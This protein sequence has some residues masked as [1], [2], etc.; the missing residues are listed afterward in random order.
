MCQ[1]LFSK[2]FTNINS[3][4]P[5]ERL[6]ERLYG[7]SALFLVCRRANGCSER[8]REAVEPGLKTW[9]PLSPPCSHLP[10]A[11][12]AK[13]LTAISLKKKDI[14]CTG[15][16]SCL[17]SGI[18]MYCLKYTLYYYTYINIY[19]LKYISQCAYTL[20]HFIRCRCMLYIYLYIIYIF[21]YTL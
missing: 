15:I 20:I 3:L 14:A 7:E 13:H 5:P 10:S 11:S 4:K 2:C 21:Y 1:A 6:Y 8:R 16:T 12:Q 18:V 19:Y 17:F 9:Q